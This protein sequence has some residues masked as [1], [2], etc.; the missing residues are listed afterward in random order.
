MQGLFCVIDFEFSKTFR[1]E[2]FKK[3]STVSI[4]FLFLTA[5]ATYYIFKIA[6]LGLRDEVLGAENAWI[7]LRLLE[8]LKVSINKLSRFNHFF[9]KRKKK[10]TTKFIL[11]K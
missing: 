5:I 8:N 9:L 1:E 4:R 6:C 2:D 3:L 10:K 11:L 7:S